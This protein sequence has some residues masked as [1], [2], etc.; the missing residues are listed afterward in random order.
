MRILLDTNIFIPLEDSSINIDEKLAELNKIAS[1][2]HELLVH[3]ATILDLKRDKNQE[4]RERI[5]PRLKKY[6]QL[7]S[8]PKFEKDEEEFLMG[9][10][11]NDNDHI[12]NLI[13]LALKRNCVHWLVT[14]DNGIHKKA[15]AIGEYERVLRVD[16]A[17]TALLSQNISYSILYPN[18]ENIS[19][20]SIDLKNTFFD[21]LREAYSGFDD[22]FNEK[23]KREGRKTWICHEGD[24]IYAICIYN[25]E[26][27]PIVTNDNKSLRGRVLKLCTFKVAR[28]GYKT[29]ELF[30]KQA[31]NHAILNKLAHVY[32]TVEPNRH[33]RLEELFSDFGFYVYGTENEGRDIVFVKDFPQNPPKTDDSPLEYSI[34]FFPF[35]KITNN[36]V[37]LVPIKPNFHQILFPE[38]HNQTDL[39]SDVNSAGNTIKK[40]YLCHASSNLL[41]QGDILFFY[42]S[43]NEM[44][45]TSYG[46]VDAFY[47][48]NGFD[49]IIKW[50]SKR[51][52]YEKIDIEELGRK[53]VKII[54]FRLIGHL[55]KYVSFD[56]LK[57]QKIVNGYVQSITQISNDK[58][59]KIIHEA[60]LDNRLLSD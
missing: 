57:S 42:Q 47:I 27:N 22:W 17:I 55:D 31:F 3:P 7:E 58:A 5:I 4:R 25:E 59:R 10:P 40:A 46:I 16:Q 44:A 52:V 12:D 15:K 18:I 6:L 51:T 53:D 45:I 34:K 8:P 36:S 43:K 1:G 54:L 37:H 23:C 11:K 28:Y 41:K 32:V 33:D 39:L 48:E 49:N 20:H 38:T 60:K 35:I 50:V 29:G 13:L 56:W 24:N 9:V 14:E 26:K 21:S 2:K 19:C 30:L